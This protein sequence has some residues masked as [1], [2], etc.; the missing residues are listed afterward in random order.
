[1]VDV[2]E[3]PAEEGR[4]AKAHNSSEIA[5]LRTVQNAFLQTI[6]RFIH[7]NQADAILYLPVIN[8]PSIISAEESV[9]LF[10]DFFPFLLAAGVVI[11]SFLIFLALETG[12]QQFDWLR[13]NL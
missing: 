3:R 9:Y 13:P 7:H 2:S 10:I 5:I 8:F 1:M 11:E 6:N 12:I 4:E